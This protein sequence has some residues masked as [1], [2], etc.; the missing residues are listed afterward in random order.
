MCDTCQW[1]KLL[2]EIEEMQ[3]AGGYEFAH[4]ALS[5]IYETVEEKEHCTE[6]QWEA[7]RNI[8]NSQKARER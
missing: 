7:V 4:H 3:Q 6:R 2:E 5:G 8:K 1:D